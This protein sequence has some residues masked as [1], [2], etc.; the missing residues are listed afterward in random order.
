[1]NDYES[2]LMWRRYLPHG[3]SEG[4]ALKTSVGRLMSSLKFEQHRY[5]IYTGKIFYGKTALD[6][7]PRGN[8]FPIT[9]TLEAF[10][11][12]IRFRDDNEFRIVLDLSRE[13]NL[14]N[15]QGGINVP[16]DLH[17]LVSL[18]YVA[19]GAPKWFVELIHRVLEQADL[20]KVRVKLSDLYRAPY[21]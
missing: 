20:E 21:T 15:S 10:C 3:I 11:K 8:I 4:I 16:V 13:L 17:T 14:V 2:E 6:F 12:D 7:Q 9:E 19:P 18:V 5:E 1:M